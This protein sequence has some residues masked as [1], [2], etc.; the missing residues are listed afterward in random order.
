MAAPG[1]GPRQGSRPSSAGPRGG[2][3]GLCSS[4]QTGARRQG[5]E[6]GVADLGARV[7]VVGVGVVGAQ[8]PSLLL[9]GTSQ[10][11]AMSWQVGAMVPSGLRQ[12]SS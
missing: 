8:Q 7:L 3:H 6:D 12:S 10:V 11:A 9:S 1:S 2:T 4:S 5:A